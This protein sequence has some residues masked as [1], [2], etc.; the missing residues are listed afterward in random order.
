MQ[1]IVV[2][3]NVAQAATSVPD[4][5]DEV[6]GVSSRFGLRPKTF[7]SKNNFCSLRKKLLLNLKRATGF[8]P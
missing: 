5:A 4:Y 3:N 2:S 8:A 6:F 1:L 7:M